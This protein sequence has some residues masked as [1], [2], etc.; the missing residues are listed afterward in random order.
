MIGGDF[1]LTTCQFFAP[2]PGFKSLP[3]AVSLTGR[4]YEAEEIFI[5]VESLGRRKA[6][7]PCGIERRTR[8]LYSA[9]SWREASIMLRF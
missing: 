9:K 7:M 3:V 2:P 8:R 4:H 6:A 1:T 5:Q